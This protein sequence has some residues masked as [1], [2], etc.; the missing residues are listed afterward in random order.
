MTINDL[1]FYLVEIACDGRE[2][3]V[4]SVLVRLAADNGLEGW[5]E[6]NLSWRAAELSARR[7]QYLPIVAGRSV[8]DIEELLSLEPPRSA[9]LRCAL[10]MACWDLVGKTANQPLCHLFGGGYRRRIPLAVRLADAPAEQMAQL[11][12]EFADQ[13]FNSQI[14]SSSG[15]VERDLET[16]GAIRQMVSDR[17]ELQLDAAAGYDIDSARHLCTELEDDSP[18][19]V[20][21]P[22]AG[23]R[24]DQIASLRRQTSVPLAV[25]RAIQTPADMLALCRCGAARSVVID[26]HLVGGLVPARECAAIAKAGGLHVSLG[27]EPSVGISTAAM[28]QLAASTPA[29]TGCNECAYYQLKDDLLTEPLETVDGMITV[30]QAPG[31][32][33]EIDRAKIEQYQVT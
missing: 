24:L 4:G 27:G 15:I 25:R 14:V 19:F 30:P 1:E 17:V 5:G 18:Q 3:P 32:G 29:F 2:S 23:H 28:L 7:E 8:F 11:A 20:V 26:L 13:G 6:A 22:L 9:P 31:L 10:E 12:R 33:I 16:L 21:D